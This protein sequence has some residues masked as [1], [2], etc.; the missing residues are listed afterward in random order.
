VASK[1][2]SVRV[3]RSLRPPISKSARAW[4]AI[5]GAAVRMLSRIAARIEPALIDI[6][7]DASEPRSC[8]DVDVIVTA[9]PAIMARDIGGRLDRVCAHD[10]AYPPRCEA[11]ET[12]SLSRR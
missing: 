1:S 7:R 3:A 9:V 8:T 6:A 11:A 12:A 10:L 2:A 5:C 4:P